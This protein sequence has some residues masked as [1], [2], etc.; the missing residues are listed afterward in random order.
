MFAILQGHVRVSVSSRM[1]S[2]AH[3]QY[4]EH[5]AS[6]AYCSPSSI[7]RHVPVRTQENT[8]TLRLCG[9]AFLRAVVYTCGGS[10]WRRLMGEEN[11]FPDAQQLWVGED[12]IQSPVVADAKRKDSTISPVILTTHL[13]QKERRDRTQTSHST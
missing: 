12:L 2:P 3:L 7:F 8:N 9:R 11:T 10:R 6:E 13:G 4:Q 1:W 5:D